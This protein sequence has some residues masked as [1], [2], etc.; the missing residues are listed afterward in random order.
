MSGVDVHHH[1]GATPG[2]GVDGQPLAEK[3]S[4]H[5]R[6]LETNDL[7]QAVM[8]PSPVYENPEGIA[9]TRQI[10]DELA[11]VA[12]EYDEDVLATLGTVEPTYGDR[13]LDEI[14]RVLEDLGLPGLMW[15]NRLQK[16]PVNDDIMYNYVERTGDRGGV[17]VLHAIAGSSLNAPWRVRELVAAFPD[18]QF[19]VLDVFSSWDQTKQILQWG[20]EHPNVTFDTGAASFLTHRIE[21]FVDQVGVDQL[22]LGTDYYTHLPVREASELAS[23][24]AT[25]LT[26]GEKRAIREDNARK[27]FG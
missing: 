26:D 24:A 3:M 14:D 18:I 23:L 10:N 11:T 16:V 20:A 13:G 8:M 4:R 9:D 17:V 12:R 6:M 2:R 5:S 15:H 19:M 7:D 21:D 22:V 1:L 25:D 27:L